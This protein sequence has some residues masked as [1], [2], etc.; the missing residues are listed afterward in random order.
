MNKILI[1]ALFTLIATAANAKTVYYPEAACKEILSSEY[2][3]GGGD[4]SWEMYEI[5]CRDADGRY[6]TFV[7]SWASVAGFFGMGR[8]AYEETINLVPYNGTILKAE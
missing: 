2:S 1:S 8:I 3:T 6:T 7:T 5:L 4:S